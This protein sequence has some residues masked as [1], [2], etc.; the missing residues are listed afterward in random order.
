MATII[1]GSAIALPM[2]AG[3]V[4]AAGLLAPYQ[5]YP[6][7][8]MPDAVAIGDVTGDGRP[9]VVMTTSFYFDPAND[10]RLWVFAQG[11]NGTLEPP[12]SY[13]TAATYTDRA[14]SVAVGDI[15]GDGRADVLLG[16]GGL[17][18]QVF[19]Q[20]AS[21]TLGS[22]ALH[23]TIDSDRIRLGQLDGDGR[24]DVAGVGWGSDTVSVLLNDGSG[25]FGAPTAY[26][27]RHDGYDDLEVADVS[28][29]GLDD[30]VVMSG[31]G[32]VPNLSIV[33]QL[34]SGGFGPAAEYQIGGNVLTHGIGVGDV[35]GDG[36]TDVVASYG[37]NKPSSFVAV[38][39]QTAGGTL[40]APVSYGSYDIPEPLDVADMDLDGRAD[41]VTL[42]GGWNQAGMYRQTAGGM[43]AAEDLYPIPYATHYDPH[44]LAI[45]D[46]TGDGAPDV[47]LADYN[48]GLVV[49]RNTPPGPATTP[50]APSIVQA[51]S[52]NA[53]V[54]LGWTAPASDG[55]SPITGY[56]IYRANVYEGGGAS[57][58]ASVGAVLGY[59]DTTAANGSLYTYEVSAVNAIG[60][61][62][63]SNVVNGRPRTIPDAPILT[64]A[65][66]GNT[67]V[68]L[69]WD[70]PFDG[71]QPISRF[72]ATAS[73]GGAMCH[74]DVLGCTIQGLTNGT[75]YTFTVRASNSVGDGPESN[76]LSATPQAPGQPP[77]APQNLAL[78]PNMPEGILITWTA[79]AS[80]G[81]DP[82]TRYLVY[83][84]DASG[85]ETPLETT[86]NVLSWTDTTA[87]KGGTYYY[88]VAALSAA[89][90]G[91]RS[92]E[93]SAQRGTAP[94]AP[95]TLTASGNGPGGVNLKWSAPTLNGG[96]AVT[97]YRIYRATVSGGEVYIVSA[98]ATATSYAD[99]TATKGVRYFYWVTAVNVLGVG[100]P[101]NEANAVAK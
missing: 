12:M 39:A 97:G 71:G 68:T 63:H 27:A 76:A 91:P 62:P 88:Q 49:L 17:G 46:V 28:G 7:G 53:Q 89:G 51:F 75:T 42:H 24:L 43:L 13:A 25:G 73:P 98:A 3:G 74:T 41:V 66:P 78:S 22:P 19:P 99:K 67:T 85:A 2:T 58:L 77:S 59:T 55:G 82:V 87:V 45:G 6:V 33:P 92:A 69:T 57:L 64:S 86:F 8:S 34:A 35:T 38:F 32:L 83:R 29:D 11:T 81:T 21:G 79:P 93:R 37:G 18:V 9:D 90:E 52:G 48:N 100:Q 1:L 61:G 44:G 15:T 31:Q 96:S 30:L 10:F 20:D 54:T 80:S 36:R 50:A 72:H 101:S 84:G 65:T 40:A 56:N 95:R 26:P 60:E 14:E 23:A 16:L 4:A 47:V 70:P 5:A 94:S